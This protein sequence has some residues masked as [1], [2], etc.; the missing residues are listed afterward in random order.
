MKHL[1]PALSAV[2]LVLACSGAG[3]GSDPGS[4]TSFAGSGGTG[5]GAAITVVG[6]QAG[7]MTGVVG[8]SGGT[9]ATGGMPATGGTPTTGGMPAFGG[10]GGTT[11]TGG[12]GGT[13]AGGGGSG[14]MMAQGGGGSGGM[15]AM[16]PGAVAY[17][18]NCY[19]CHGPEGRGSM[20]QIPLG[21]EIQHPVVDFATYMVRTGSAMRDP[22]HA[23]WPAAMA[24][25]P[26]S[27][28]APLSDSDLTLILDYLDSFPKPTTAQGLYEDYCANCHGKDGHGGTSTKNLTTVANLAATIVTKVRG[29]V[30][31]GQFQ[32]LTDYMPKR[33]APA[34]GAMPTNAQLTDAELML[35]TTYVDALP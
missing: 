4:T 15:A 33:D 5:G 34:G 1:I 8:G 9:P 17:Q 27:G 19:A 29:G 32:K 20:N 28:P 22:N 24:P 16:S 10:T 12:S 31:L 2:T 21:P 14:G 7:S 18:V 11:T 35:I 13:P 30:N 25:I 6:G 26:N 3:T 23:M